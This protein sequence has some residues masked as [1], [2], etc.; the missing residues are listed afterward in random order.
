MPFI[1]IWVHLVFAVKNRQPLLSDSIR[2]KL[3]A[4]IISYAKS[5]E[6]F[7]DSINGYA[8]HIHCLLSMGSEQTISKIA[9]LLK[10]ESSHWINS[11]KITKT[12][13]E[14]ADEYFAA[15][16]SQSQ[17]NIVRNY[18]NHQEEHHRT[19]SFNEE[20]NAFMKKYGFKLLG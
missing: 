6:I 14:W 18:I 15:S 11:V 3:I 19:K 17:I 13:F 16:V 12:K 7:I 10:G 4:H 2:A 1:R 9:N 8:E 5:K 20:Y